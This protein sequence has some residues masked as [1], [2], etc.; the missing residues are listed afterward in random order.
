MT[1]IG[2]ANIRRQVAINHGKQSYSGTF[3]LD[4]YDTN[5]DFLAHLAVNVSAERITAD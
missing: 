5:R 2:P 3:T 4:Q 1:F